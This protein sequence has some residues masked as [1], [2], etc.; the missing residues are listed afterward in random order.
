MI[1]RIQSV[2]L[3]VAA[4]L[5]VVCLSLPV[6]SLEMGTA[7]LPLGGT[8]AKEALVYNLWITADGA[9]ELTTW[10]LFLLL[11]CSAA[12]A[13]YTIFGYRNR[14]MQARF[15]MFTSMLLVG[16]HILAAVYSQ[17]LV[18]G[19]TRMAFHNEPA[20]ILPLFSLILTIMARRAILKDEKLVRAADRIR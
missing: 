6:A 2:F 4:I 12:M 10:P 9:K 7:T 3:L 19:Q 17:I 11:A 16:W 20:S 13:I 14:I 1:Q 8:V 18:D 15:C 5:A